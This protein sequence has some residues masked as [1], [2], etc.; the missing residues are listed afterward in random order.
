MDESGNPTSGS[1]TFNRANEGGQATGSGNQSGSSGGDNDQS[2]NAAATEE[3]NPND[4]RNSSANLASS[5]SPYLKQLN[6]TGA[7]STSNERL[8]SA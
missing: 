1:G 4:T 2:G 6:M 5:G 3:D 7:E 8:S